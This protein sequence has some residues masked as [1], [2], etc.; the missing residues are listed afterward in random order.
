[1]NVTSMPRRLWW[2]IVPLGLVLV[3]IIVVAFLDE[4]LRAYAER[5]LNERLPAYVFQIGTLDLHPLTLSLDLENVTVRQ[6]DHPD[7]PIAALATWHAS[8]QWAALLS[9]RLVTDQSIESPVIHFTRPEVA[10]ELDP[11]PEKEQSWQE[12]LFA[13][14]QVQVNEV[15][16]T[17]GDVTYREH[18]TAK[19][20]HITELDIRAKNIRNVRSQPHEYPSDLHIAAVVFDKGRFELDGHADFFA[21]PTMA[22]NA[23][24]TLTDITMA[25][26]SPILAQ[27][28]VHLSQGRLSA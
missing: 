19:P 14:H 22:V 25:D 11:S 10:K 9:G 13:M 12:A 1:M 21:E 18:A 27:H 7:P 3:L 28:Q 16:I 6:K 17:H 26:L 2:I 23:D 8:I 24:L 5:E 15:H 4:P 20:L